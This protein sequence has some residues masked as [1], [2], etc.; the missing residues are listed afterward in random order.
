MLELCGRKWKSD[1]DRE[2]NPIEIIWAKGRF[3]SSEHKHKIR[4]HDK[5]YSISSLFILGG[6]ILW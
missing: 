2:K 1:K 5:L 6:K 4:I 3:T